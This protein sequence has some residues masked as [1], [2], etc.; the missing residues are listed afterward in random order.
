MKYLLTIDRIEGEEVEGTVES[1]SFFFNS[2][3]PLNSLAAVLE[4]IL[5]ESQIVNAFMARGI[6]AKDI[7]EAEVVDEDNLFVGGRTDF[8]KNPCE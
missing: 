7:I 1:R 4:S 2:G 3:F 8:Q 5:G 6:P